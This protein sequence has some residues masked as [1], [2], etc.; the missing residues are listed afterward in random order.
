MFTKVLIANR[1]AIACRIIRTLKKLGVKSVA[2]YSEADLASLHVAQADEAVCIGPAPAAESYLRA[3]KILE[4]ARETG[5]QAIHPG[6]GFL[7]E[8]ADFAAACERAGVAFIGPS[9]EQMRAFGLKH[10]ARELAERNGVPL[11][12]GSGLLGGIEQARTEAARIGYPVM[13]KS[14]AGG[15]GIGMRLIQGA[16]ELEE[17]YASVE[18]LA[19]ANFKDAGIYLEKYV[20]QARHIEVQIFGDGR[21]KVIALGERDCSVQRR[22]QKVIEET[23]APNLSEAVR[24]ELLATSVRLAQAVG[25]RSAGTVEYVFDAATGEFYFL[26]VNTRLQV[27]HGVTEE[28]TGVD[29]VE[30]M[31]RCASGD[32]P[33]LD[34]LKPVAKG[35]SIQVRLYAEDPG[36]NFQPCSGTLTAVDFPRNAR[37]ET[38]VERGNE[39][40]PNYD[41]MIAKI[42]VHAADRR[43]ALKKLSA[44][45]ADTNIGG[46]ETNLDYLRQIIVDP[47]FVA[48][49]QTT[50]MLAG[51]QYRQFAIEVIE[52][53]V[54]TSVQD[55]PGRLGYWDVGVPPSGPMDALALR[56]ANRLLGNAQGAAGL[57]CTAVGPTLKF[58]CD[59]V[60]AIA[61]APV[62]ASL[63]GRPFAMWASHKVKAGSVL[64]VGRIAGPGL[65]AY[66]AVAGGFDVPAYL[67]ASATFTLGRFGGHSGRTLRVGDMLHP[68]AGKL[69][70]AGTRLPKALLPGYTNH[71]QIAVLYG[72]H[73]APDFFTEQGIGTFFATDWEVHYNSSRTGVR[74]IGPKPQWARPDGGEAGLHPS[75]IHDNAYAIGAI[76][77]TGDMPV[78]L[79]PDG[80]SLGGFVCPAVIVDC[81]LWKMGQLKPGD[82]VR[83][84]RVSQDWAGQMSAAADTAIETLK[85][86]AVPVSSSHQPPATSHSPVLRRI[87]PIGVQ[88]EVAYRQSGDR[89]LLV[90]YG[91]LVL[92]LNLRFRVHAL[93]HWLQQRKVDGIVD[94]T[95]G[96]RSLQ[97]HFDQRLGLKNLLELLAKAEK[98]LAAIEDMKLPARI[99]HLPLSWDD[100]AT[101]LAIEKYTQS[102]RKDA[103]WCPSNIEFIRRINGLD[104]IDDVHRIVF[105]ASYLVLGL[106]DVYLG[107]PVATPMDPRHRLVTTKYNPARTWTPENA[108]GIGGAYLCVYGMEGPGGY[109]FVGRTLQMWNR[110]KQTDAFT[111][112]KP[113][114][115]RFFDQIRFYPVSEQ[116]LLKIREDFPLGRYPLR[117]E[118]TT[119]SLREYNG[120][121]E[122]NAGSI[123]A[124]KSRQ[125]AAFEAERER[126]KAAGQADYATEDS[127]A[128]AGADTRHELP[129][130]GRAV[131]SQ[132]AGNVWK[133]P[134]KP[135]DRVAEGDALVIVESMKMEFP[136]TAPCAGKVLQVF[137]QE[138]S[139]V[140]AGQDLIVLEARE[141]TGEGIRVLRDSGT[142]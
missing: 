61:G 35:A 89:Y 40:P 140:A 43:A 99:V 15:G 32:L 53:G 2:V 135:G 87:P 56:L 49:K 83:F 105:D 79:G 78:I 4:A 117:I 21:G 110:Y 125:Q 81:E 64:K 24:T 38:W 22:N 69:P 13:L 103:P 11:L 8:N 138:G 16:G 37:V 33:P 136:V 128:E 84:V 116:E 25:Y 51:L 101:R 66:L 104:S 58:H 102:V 109:Q 76:D 122:K 133:I 63:D 28:V 100:A 72:P 112:G 88:P 120:F 45:L 59:S 119:F 94:L 86:P 90:E 142:R 68:A 85:F 73:G 14:T 108:V 46:I 82:K 114:L 23:P 47:V 118:E 62:D 42:I 26:E 48:G 132:L 139:Q 115:L 65:R 129:A 92:D 131:A 18:R 34:S 50:R 113:W 3:D 141:G 126:W 70:A 134:V 10:R 20:Q 121:L 55:W 19:R 127:D 98:E 31:V 91:P 93:M 7:S 71:W 137:C 12:P 95:P 41:P 36:R 74:L 67:G 111:E 107:A 97:V 124:F 123:A 29:L 75:N 9:A 52:P 44:A 106:G 27:E 54:Q 96:I 5:A 17:A 57:E 1:G 39:V 80:P 77:F 6:Y 30:W 130:N 60:I